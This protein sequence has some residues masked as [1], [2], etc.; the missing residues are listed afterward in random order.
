MEKIRIIARI[1]RM[2]RNSNN[3]HLHIAYAFVRSLTAK[4]EVVHIWEN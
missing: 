2:L 4:E 3:R 1:V